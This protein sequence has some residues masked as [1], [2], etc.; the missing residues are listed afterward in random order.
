MTQAHEVNYAIDPR[1]LVLLNGI[2]LEVRPITPK[3]PSPPPQPVQQQNQQ[4]GQQQ[5]QVSK[6]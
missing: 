4:N 3:A 6:N 5:Q 1:H 2:E